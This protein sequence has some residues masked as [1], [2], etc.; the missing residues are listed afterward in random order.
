MQKK[1]ASSDIYTNV[2][3]VSIVMLQ[4]SSVSITR[5]TIKHVTRLFGPFPLIQVVK[6]ITYVLYAV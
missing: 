5:A 4:N 3:R 1:S 6:Q 2:W